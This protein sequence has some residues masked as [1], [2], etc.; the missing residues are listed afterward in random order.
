MRA[1]ERLT[2]LEK[3]VY[4]NL[5]KGREMKAPGKN[6]DITDI[7]RQEPVTNL[8]WQPMHPDESNMLKPDPLA[9]CPGILIMP[10]QNH[11]KKIEERRFDRY[12][13]VN[14]P[15]EYGQTFNVQ[16]LFSVYEPGIRLP[17]FVE[18]WESE[19]GCD[20]TKLVE[21]T[22]AGLFTLLNWMD[23]CTS[24]LLADIYI[25][26]TD[27]ILHEEELTSGL[28]TDQSFIVDKRPIYYGFVYAEFGCYADDRNN[29][30]INNL[31]K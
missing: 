3:W 17:G 7:R 30:Y 20:M 8:G 26:H 6:M 9:V 2:M 31:L 23:D 29:S 5:C 11:A 14:R 22:R 13:G 27:L 28:L 4:E 1:S 12:N 25:P 10:T 18:S 21:G 19:D 24:Q 15:K 16:M